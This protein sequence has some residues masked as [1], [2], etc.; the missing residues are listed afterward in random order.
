MC[1]CTCPRC[2]NGQGAKRIQSQS[3]PQVHQWPDYLQRSYEMLVFKLPRGAQDMMVSW[4]VMH[5]C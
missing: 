3:M 5:E 4:F 1:V 2:T